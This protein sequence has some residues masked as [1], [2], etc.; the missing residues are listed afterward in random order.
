MLRWLPESEGRDGAEE[1]G[2]TVV[3][4][5][6]AAGW[7]Q[8]VSR[9]RGGGMP[10]TG[11]VRRRRSA[12]GWFAVLAAWRFAVLVL[13]LRVSDPAGSGHGSGKS[14]RLRNSLMHQLSH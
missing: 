9:C 5:A 7:L 13:K 6:W 12:A 2:G 11:P 4:S 10:A 8:P 1:A 3:L 14:R